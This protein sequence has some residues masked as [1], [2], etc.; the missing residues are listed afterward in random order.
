MSTRPLQRSSLGGAHTSG[1]QKT[2]SRRLLCVRVAPQDT[3]VNPSH[4]LLYS[5]R[6]SPPGTGD[7]HF[8]TEE[9]K[10]KKRSL[11][12]ILLSLALAVASSGTAY[13]WTFATQGSPQSA[14]YNGVSFGDGA[15]KIYRQGFSSIY[16][17]VTLRDRVSN[18]RGVY[19][20]TYV[21]K[22]GDTRWTGAS[23]QTGRRTDQATWASMK[24]KTINTVRSSAGHWG[25]SKVCEDASLRPDICSKN[26]SRAL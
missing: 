26:T 15:G 23:T 19:Q 1:S 13:A 25:R 10:A 18:G 8:Y 24:R 9:D 3:L 20:D 7:S 4:L 6:P 12:A 17:D 11:S 21:Y 2:A 16:I 5:M 22:P 14:I